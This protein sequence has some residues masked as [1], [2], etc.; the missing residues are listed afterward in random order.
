VLTTARRG[1]AAS[2]PLQ[3]HLRRPADRCPSG[4]LRGELKV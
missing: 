4:R 2:E 1:V 3:M